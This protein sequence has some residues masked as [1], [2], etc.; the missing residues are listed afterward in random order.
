MSAKLHKQ[1][2]L[3]RKQINQLFEFHRSHMQKATAA[4]PDTSDCLAL[5]TMLHSF[6]TGVEN[7]FKRIAVGCDGG[8]PEGAGWHQALLES[9]TEAGRG[10]P[11]VISPALAESLAP[12]LEFRHLFRHGYSF[13]LRWEKMADLTLHCEQVWRQTEAE[14]QKF[15]DAIGKGP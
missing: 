15:L 5:A 8:P 3:E 6:Y 14:L 10:R 12:Y 13:D 2:V 11:P 1:V 9:M 7:V 4:R